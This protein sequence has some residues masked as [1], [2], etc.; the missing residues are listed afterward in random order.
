MEWDTYGGNLLWTFD[1]N[2]GVNISLLK[3]SSGI[4]L[5]KQTTH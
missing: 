1:M 5:L 3:V 2:T 4:N